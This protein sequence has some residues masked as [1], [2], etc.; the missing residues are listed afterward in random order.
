MGW[1]S[2]EVS[3][4]VPGDIVQFSYEKEILL[5]AVGVSDW[6]MIPRGVR[7]ISISLYLT[8]SATASVETTMDLIRNVKAGTALFQT[9]ARGIVL[10]DTQDS[11]YTV[12]AMRLNQVTLG[13]NGTARLQIRT[14]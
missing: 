13:I 12:T 7:D 4:V 2:M 14:T 8:G 10:K 6:I 5:D 11:C 9:W 3:P 1:Q